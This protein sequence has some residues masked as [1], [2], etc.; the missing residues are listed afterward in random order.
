M[1]NFFKASLLFVGGALVIYGV[2]VFVVEE[3]MSRLSNGCLCSICDFC[4]EP[5]DWED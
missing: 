2:V 3:V 1:K 4:E 5:D